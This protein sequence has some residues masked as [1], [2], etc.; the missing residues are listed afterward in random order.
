MRF[1]IA[2][3]DVPPDAAARRLGITLAQFTSI[4]PNLI[5]RGFPKADPDTANFDLAAIERWCDLR[6]S[7]LLNGGAAM[8]ARDAREV[9]GDRLAAMRAA[10]RNG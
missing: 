10:A 8:T 1:R 3:R 4:L 7:H 6:H 9:V 5:A 2:P